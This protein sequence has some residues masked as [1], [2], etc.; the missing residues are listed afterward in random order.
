MG[1][2]GKMLDFECGWSNHFAEGEQHHQH[3]EDPVKG[4]YEALTSWQAL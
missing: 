2:L 3:S 1:G 4:T